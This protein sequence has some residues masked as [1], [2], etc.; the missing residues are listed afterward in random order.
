MPILKKTGKGNVAREENKL[1][2]AKAVPK[3]NEEKVHKKLDSVRTRAGLNKRALTRAVSIETVDFSTLARAVNATGR[4][5]VKTE[6]IEDKLRAFHT[7]LEQL[8]GYLGKAVWINKTTGKV[9]VNQETM[10]IACALLA[11]DHYFLHHVHDSKSL[12]SLNLKEKVSYKNQMALEYS[13]TALT[14]TGF[15]VQGLVRRA[16]EML[17]TNRKNHAFHEN[18]PEFPSIISVASERF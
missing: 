17:E 3:I 18:F 7:N 9:I 12:A 10:D 2:K 1:S 13:E 14:T 5:T 8:K 4:I 6:R 16:K 15:S 11:F